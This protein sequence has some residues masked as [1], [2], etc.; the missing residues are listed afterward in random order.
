METQPQTPDVLQ[1]I[2]FCRQHKLDAERVGGWI[3][4]SFPD[5]PP[6]A[7]RTQLKDIGFR[8]SAS[9]G[10]W[11]HNCGKPCL[12]AQQSNPWDTYEHYLVSR[13]DEKTI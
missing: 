4:V 6:K 3:W 12:S 9:R 1:V 8:W 7:L 5:K 11:A 2:D 13:S 10:K